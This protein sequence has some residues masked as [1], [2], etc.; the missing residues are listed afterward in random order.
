[1]NVSAM[2]KQINKKTQTI[3]ISLDLSKFKTRSAV[4]YVASHEAWETRY[5]RYEIRDIEVY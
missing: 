4:F 1:M 2:S 5:F 3:I